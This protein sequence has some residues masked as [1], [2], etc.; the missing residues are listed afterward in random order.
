MITGNAIA[1]CED[2]IE[3]RVPP[4]FPTSPLHL[5][6]EINRNGSCSV[7]VDFVLDENGNVKV[8]GSSPSRK[9]C[10]YFMFEA[11]RSVKL[12]E[13]STGIEEQCQIVL[14]FQMGGNDT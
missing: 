10:S 14:T 9:R 4:R 8:T 6:Q 1:N 2:R 7:T 13:Y 3:K 11:E 5:D 12:Y